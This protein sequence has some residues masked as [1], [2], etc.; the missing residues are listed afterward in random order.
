MA[1][2]TI[3]CSDFVRRLADLSV[4]LLIV[5]FCYAAVSKLISFELF[6]QQMRNQTIP[7]EA[8]EILVYLL[9]A[10][11]IITAGLLIHPF[12]RRSGLAASAVLMLA[13]SGYIALVLL[14]F[15]DRVPCSC[16]GILG[17]LGWGTHLVFNL[18]FLGTALFALIKQNTGEA[19][20][21]RKE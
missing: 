17:G 5:L 18:F 8:A 19:E 10:L 6:R 7:A 11:E 15:W 12:T 21:L 3:H 1:G 20:N 13:F 16:G 4:S 2:S 14:G 9:P